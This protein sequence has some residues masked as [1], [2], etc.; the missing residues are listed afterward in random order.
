MNTPSDFEDLIE[1]RVE[2]FIRTGAAHVAAANSLVVSTLVRF[3]DQLGIR[4]GVSPREALD[5]AIDA[6]RRCADRTEG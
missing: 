1:Q 2:D 5:R 4:D 3:A 6:A